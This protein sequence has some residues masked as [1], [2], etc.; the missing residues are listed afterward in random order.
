[1]V[2]DRP[3]KGTEMIM[4]AGT[5]PAPIIAG[6]TMFTATFGR[7]LVPKVAENAFQS[8]TFVVSTVVMSL[9]DTSTR[10]VDG[11]ASRA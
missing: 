2:R 10:S 11:I 3:R 7:A 4:G 8:F 1:M 9:A 6:P 5:I